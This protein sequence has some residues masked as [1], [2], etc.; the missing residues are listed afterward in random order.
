MQ[1]KKKMQMRRFH[2]YL[3]VSQLR[4]ADQYSNHHGNGK[5]SVTLFMNNQTELITFIN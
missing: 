2:S 4:A 1:K 3:E 5:V